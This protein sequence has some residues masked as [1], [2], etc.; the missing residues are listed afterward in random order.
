[1]AQVYKY[2]LRLDSPEKPFK[3]TGVIAASLIKDLYDHTPISVYFA[4]IRDRYGGVW[5][6]IFGRWDSGLERAL[7]SLGDLDLSMVAM[8]GFSSADNAAKKF[9]VGLR[10]DEEA[11]SSAEVED[12]RYTRFTPDY[13]GKTPNLQISRRNIGEYKKYSPDSPLVLRIAGVSIPE[14][15][16]VAEVATEILL[17]KI[18]KQT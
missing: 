2:E 3:F 10:P 5:A 7:R 17:G 11:A 4:D 15:K 18:D 9:E 13:D 1:M 12:F 8:G 14:M 6:P 16:I